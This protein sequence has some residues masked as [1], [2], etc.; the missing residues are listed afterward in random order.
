MQ[1]NCQLRIQVNRI[2]LTTND[3]GIENR[4]FDLKYRVT[5]IFVDIRIWI[6]QSL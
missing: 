4:I 1:S 2:H 6:V 3:K 5:E